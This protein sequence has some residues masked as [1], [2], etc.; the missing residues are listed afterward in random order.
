MLSDPDIDELIARTIAPPAP[1]APVIHDR[2]R[3][4]RP[5]TVNPHLIPL[6]RAPHKGEDEKD[7]EDLR[8]VDVMAPAR[9]IGAAVLA[10]LPFW[11]VCG[12]IVLYFGRG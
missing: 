1:E 7:E 8:R 2:R 9:G 5:K 6:L 12:A 4:G 11:A 3:P 10:C